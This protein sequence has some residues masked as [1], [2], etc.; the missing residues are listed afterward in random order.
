MVRVNEPFRACSSALTGTGGC[1]TDKDGFDITISKI[2]IFERV[3]TCADV[4]NAQFR[5]H[6]VELRPNERSIEINLQGR[7]PVAPSMTFDTEER[8]ARRDNVQV[9]FTQGWGGGAIAKGSAQ[10]PRASMRSGTMT[11]RFVT[12]NPNLPT[13]GSASGTIPFSVCP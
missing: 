11:F 12:T 6:D 3:V 1:S 7:W 10:F 13:S 2:R 9:T 8:D 4:G 5:R